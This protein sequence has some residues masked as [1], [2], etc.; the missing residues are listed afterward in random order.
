[1]KPRDQAR[2]DT[3]DDLRANQWGA[4]LLMFVCLGAAIFISCFSWR[5]DQGQDSMGRTSGFGLVLLYAGLSGFFFVEWFICNRKHRRLRAT[6][7]E[8]S[9]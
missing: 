5:A 9:K 7:Q 6:M 3:L 8:P 4:L 2:Q 1:M